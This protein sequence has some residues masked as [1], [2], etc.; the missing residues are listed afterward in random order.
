ML[1]WT[2]FLPD[3]ARPRSQ[4]L[5]IGGGCV[6]GHPCS[7]LPL[8]FPPWVNP[9]RCP[10]AL[11]FAPVCFSQ[12]AEKAAF[13][14]GSKRRRWLLQGINK[15]NSEVLILLVWGI[16]GSLSD[17]SR[18]GCSF[19][20]PGRLEQPGAV[21]LGLART[22]PPSLTAAPH[23]GAAFGA[24]NVTKVT[25]VLAVPVRAGEAESVG[26]G[27]QAEPLSAGRGGECRAGCTT[28]AVR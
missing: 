4:G 3:G 12:L 25:D 5:K 24:E 22:V 26:T 7:V 18:G 16:F 6:L 13:V 21:A 11:S 10:L 23:R 28:A 14:R 9:S 19:P 27:G 2:R 17:F 20:A 8:F 15:L 1:K